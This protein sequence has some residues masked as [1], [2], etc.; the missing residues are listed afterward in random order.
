MAATVEQWMSPDPLTITPGAS[1]LEAHGMMLRHGIRHL[2]VVGERGQLVGILSVDDLRAALPAGTDL[3]APLPASERPAASD[4]LVGELMSFAP[5]TLGPGAELARAAERMAARRIGCLPI[6][7][8][9]GRLVGL[10]SETDLLH[11]LANGLGAPAARV[12]PLA[13]LVEE[14]RAEHLAL[15]QKLGRYHAEERR[16]TGELGEV[17][18][19]QAERGTRRE[20][21]LR[22]E[23]LE[24]LA[25]RRLAALEHALE[26][27]AQGRLGACEG[28]GA[29]IP[30]ARLRALP[31]STRCIDCVRAGERQGG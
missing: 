3:R 31:G 27:A 6:V 21:L 14:L 9:R 5:E 4:F 11:A 24:E 15:S 1:A 19:D 8:A 22:T 12:S 23:G 20:E 13:A 29:T 25:G 18:T 10:L 26:R 7:D 30:V 17:P 2:P 16:I 28:C